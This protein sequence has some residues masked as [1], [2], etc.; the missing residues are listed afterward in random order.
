MR[1]VQNGNPTELGTNKCVPYRIMKNQKYNFFISYSK[2]DYKYAQW[3]E[4]AFNEAGYTTLILNCDDINIGEID[5]ALKNSTQFVAILSEEYISSKECEIAWKGAFQKA[6]EEEKTRKDN[7]NTPILPLFIP[8]KVSDVVLK[9]ILAQLVYFPLDEIGMT[10]EG[11]NKLLDIIQPRPFNR[12]VLGVFHSI[13][14]K[15]KKDVLIRLPQNRNPYFTG[16]KEVLKQIET[17]LQK[18]GIVSLVQTDK[19]FIGIG[20]SSIAFEYAYI[21]LE[22]YDTIWWVNADDFS[23]ALEAYKTLAEKKKIITD[24]ATEEEIIKAVKNWFDNNKNWLFIFDNAKA[25]DYNI[26][27]NQFF[28]KQSVYNGHLII[29]TRDNFYPRSPV[30]IYITAFNNAECVEFLQK[31]IGKFGDD[32]TDLDALEL[33]KLLKQSPLVIEQ[34]ASYI[35]ENPGVGYQDCMNLINSYGVGFLQNK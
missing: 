27:L 9:G 19:S 33:S 25:T 6:T 7:D 4:N 20:K 15:P 24:Q 26:W 2:N 12:P 32:Y 22:E 17:E 1:S 35:E 13:Y 3:V 18:R 14:F 23:N 28:P 10:E 21:H 34:I 30:K 8:I 5:N 11:R 29:T 31:R 16:R